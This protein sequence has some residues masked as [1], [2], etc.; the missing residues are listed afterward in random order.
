MLDE[1]P[2]AP[3]LHPA[4]SASTPTGS[5]ATRDGWYHHAVADGAVRRIPK[6]RT[7]GAGGGCQRRAK[8]AQTWRVKNAHSRMPCC[9]R[10]CRDFADL[11]AYRAF[12]A[13]VVSRHN[14]RHRAR[15][16]AERELLLPL[17][18]QRTSDYEYERVY[19]TSSSG[20]ALRKVYYSVPSRLIGHTL[21][22]RLYHDRLELLLGATFLMTRARADRRQARLCGQL[23]PP[24]PLPAAQADG[25]AE[26]SVPRSVIPAP[27]LPPLLR[28]PARSHRSAHRLPLH[29]RLV[30]VG[31]RPLL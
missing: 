24:D 7:R 18:E 2:R 27:R 3:T 12:I 28:G 5:S 11:S 14:A 6:P 26:P 10:G 22:V 4:L 1:R 8:T 21:C 17:P 25:V 29:R 23:S 20:F 30:G 19:V 31:A 15:I 13:D 16:D 9:L